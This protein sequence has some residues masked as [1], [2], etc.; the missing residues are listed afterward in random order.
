MER[1]MRFGTWNVRSLY[2]SGSITRVAGE[3]TRCKL[4]LVSVQDVRCKEGG[5]LSVGDYFIF[6]GKGN[7]NHQL[8]T[9]FLYTTECYQKLE[10]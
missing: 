8:G 5:T 1:K 3:L 6:Y 10:K 7:E 4:D 9:G 2:M